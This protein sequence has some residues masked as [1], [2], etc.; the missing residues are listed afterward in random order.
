MLLKII[1][2]TI[3]LITSTGIGYKMAEKLE[4]RLRDLRSFGLGLQILEREIAFL[5]SSLPDAMIKIS[6]IKGNASA[7]FRECGE[8]L[9]EKQGYCVQ[10][11]WEMAFDRLYRDTF[12]E[13]EDRMIL[14]ELGKS[15][16]AYDIEN[17]TQNIK[18]ISSQLQIQEQKAEVNI[19]KN[20]K[21]YK[22]LGALAGL[23]IVIVL[24]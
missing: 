7:I 12:L 23:A 15:L 20:S 24:L 11:A 5:S 4:G 2:V 9:K 19:E 16:G 10:E 18:N 17:Q 8:I 6:Y 21:L 13:D 22:S 3:I 14:I 1:G